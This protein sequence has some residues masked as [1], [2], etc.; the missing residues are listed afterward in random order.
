MMK[1]GRKRA[2]NSATL[3]F[4]DLRQA[5]NEL[6]EARQYSILADGIQ[7]DRCFLLLSYE[8][9]LLAHRIRALEFEDGDVEK[10]RKTIARSE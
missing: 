10:N 8:S 3:I 6:E 4:A 9:V 2:S 1:A 7:Q 5:T